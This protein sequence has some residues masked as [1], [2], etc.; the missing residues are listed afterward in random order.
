MGK[1][2]KQRRGGKERTSRTNL[3]GETDPTNTEH[4][5]EPHDTL[6]RGTGDKG[7][8]RDQWNYK[9]DWDPVPKCKVVRDSLEGTV[10]DQRSNGH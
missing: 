6:Q 8:I 3:H 10:V 5:Q 2:T 7:K 1:R 4:A 9:V